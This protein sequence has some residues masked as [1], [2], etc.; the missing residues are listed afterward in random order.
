MSAGPPMAPWGE[1]THQRQG[2]GC[3]RWASEVRGTSPGPRGG[4]V[5]RAGL[6]LC[7]SNGLWAG[8]SCSRLG[9]W[10]PSWAPARAMSLGLG[11]LARVRGPQPSQAR[12]FP[13]LTVGGVGSGYPL[14]RPQG[15]RG[16]LGSQ[17]P[18][19][20]NLETASPALEAPSAW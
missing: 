19:L 2:W 14:E 12:P 6:Q 11:L 18:G 8:S 15:G 4:A 20:L 9:T 7:V 10:A 5:R 1:G 17:L 16:L 3:R 13:A